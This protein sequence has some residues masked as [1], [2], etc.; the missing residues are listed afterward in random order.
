MFADG[1]H[2]VIGS[3]DRTAR[4]WNAD[5]GAEVIALRGHAKDVTSVAA[6][7]DGG[8]PIWSDYSDLLRSDGF[9]RTM[10]TTIALETSKG[11]LPLAL[12][13]SLIHRVKRRCL[14][15]R[16][17]ARRAHRAKSRLNQYLAFRK[18]SCC[19]STL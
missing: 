10:T 19:L 11:D 18:N 7:R 4:I 13:L 3:S 2:I 17:P 14:R 15:G 9:T 16:L 8:M 1:T 6:T 5:T 12:A